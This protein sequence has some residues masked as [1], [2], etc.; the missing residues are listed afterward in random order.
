MRIGEVVG[1]AALIGVA[2]LVGI[3]LTDDRTPETITSDTSPFVFADSTSPPEASTPVTGAPTLDETTT[4]TTAAA[5]TT[6]DAAEPATPT[7]AAPVP[8]LIPPDQRAGIAVRVLNGGA[9]AHA[10]TMTSD[11]LRGAGFAPSGS[12]DASRTV[13]AT[14]VM[15]APGRE[16][17][18][19]TVNDVIRARPENV[20]PGAPDDSNWAAFGDGL[21]VLV[22]L[23]PV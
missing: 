17:E 23:G 7:T 14:M 19:A 22:V 20:V 6:V 4:S 2:V 18:A 5:P 1:G 8:T 3:A 12:A 11:L 15:F 13:P 16:L 21:A 9:R 10:A